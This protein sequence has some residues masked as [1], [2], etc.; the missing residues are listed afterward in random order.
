MSAQTLTQISRAQTSLL[1]NHPFFA[2]LL[3]YLELVEEPGLGTTA[4]DGEKLFYDADFVDQCNKD[5]T[6]FLM[7][8]ET[9]HGALDH[10]GRCG[11]R[12]HDLYNQA[13]DHVINLI[14]ID[15]GLTPPA[16]AL[17]DR[18]FTGMNT[19][20]VYNILDSEKQ[21]E[22]KKPEQGQ[23][24]KPSHDHGGCTCQMREPTKDGQPMDKAAKDEAAGKMKRRLVQA[25]TMAK[26]AGKMPG[27]LSELVDDLTEAKED[28]RSILRQYL[29]TE[30]AN[31]YD[32]LQADRNYLQ[33]GIVVP[34]MHNLELGTMAFIIDTSASM[35]RGRLAAVW[36]EAQAIGDEIPI[37]QLIIIQC[38]TQIACEP[39]F[40]D[41]GDWPATLEIKGRGG[42]DFRPPFKRL[43][44][45][46]IVPDVA[47][48]FTDGECSRYPAAPD[49]PVIWAVTNDPSYQKPAPFGE[50]IYID[51]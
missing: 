46:G 26:A 4:T 8:H 27:N 13:A 36:A 21:A 38:D 9:M 33:R 37:N 48:Y 18:R 19:D 24:G 47:V 50:S 10:L 12:D 43:E 28:W 1:I 42:T 5:E 51:D 41:A 15:S 2:Q 31:D 45:A 16:H 7:A 35:N 3:L 22:K 30:A 20:Q 6:I 34:S 32:W 44:D 17:A 39:T 40:H 49:Y 14:L 25:A 29:E 23:D 11:A